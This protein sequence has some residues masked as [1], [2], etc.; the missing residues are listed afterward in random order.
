MKS[1]ICLG[2]RNEINQNRIVEEYEKNMSVQANL[3]SISGVQP[4]L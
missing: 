3:S 2:S 4:Y 1:W